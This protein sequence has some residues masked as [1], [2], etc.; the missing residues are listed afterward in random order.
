MMMNDALEHRGP[1]GSGFW[2]DMAA[3]IA[4]GHRRLAIVDLTETG[5]QPMISA[6]GRYV[7]TY[8]GEIYNAEE[9]RAHGAG[10]RHRK[11]AWE[12][13]LKWWQAWWKK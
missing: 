7:I 3:G 6:G 5:H 1:D 11:T 4:L 9:L 12:R 13:F 10:H 8:N 2:G